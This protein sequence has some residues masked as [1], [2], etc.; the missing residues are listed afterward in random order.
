MKGKLKSSADF[1]G[2]AKSIHSSHMKKG[3][4][5]KTHKVI[6]KSGVGNFGQKKASS[7]KG[8]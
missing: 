1:V 6:G 7:S 2:L 3:I 8:K 4:V 5:S